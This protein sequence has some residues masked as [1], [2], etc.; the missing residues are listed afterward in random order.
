MSRLPRCRR[1]HRQTLGAARRARALLPAL[2]VLAATAPAGAQSYVNFEAGQVRPLALSP[3]GSRL[4]ATNTPDGQVEIF[5]VGAAGLTHQCSVPV[6]LEPVA[7][8]AASDTELWVVNHLSDSVSIVDVTSCAAARVRRT[9]LVGD[10]PRDIVFA[11]ADGQLAFITTA[12]R[13]QNHPLGSE[14]TTEGVGR[15]DVWVFDA[16]NLGASLEGD[17]ETIITLFGDTPRGLAV[18]RDGAR[19]YAAV[20]HSGNRTTTVNEGLVCDGGASAPACTI[21]GN[22]VPGGLP[23]P[24]V[25][26]NGV[27]GPETGLIVHW[28]P[29]TSHWEDPL[30]RNWNNAIR[31]SLPDLDVFEIDATANPPVERD[32]FAGVGTVLFNLAVNP[33]NDKVYVTNT[34]ANNAVR[35]EGPGTHSTTVRGNLHRARVTIIDPALGAVTPRPLNP[36][37]DYSVVP[38]PAGIAAKSLATPVGIVLSADGA[39]AWIAAFGSSKVGLFDTAELE[40]GTFTP[41]VANQVTVT[42]GGPSGLV[43]DEARDR[44]YVLTRFDNGIST[45][46]VGAMT[47]TAHT[48]L[49][50]PEPTAIVD[51]RPFLYDA[52]A[53][54]SNGE[55]SCSSCHVF[56]DLDSLAWDLGN[57]DDEVLT[58]ANP[59]EFGP[60]GS[61]DFHPLKGPM[62]TQSL[63]GMA[64]HGPMHW[65]GDRTGALEAASVQPDS[66]A[67]NEDAAFKKFNPAFV[68]LVGRDTTLTTA[69]MQKFTDFVLSVTYP[70]NPNRALNNAL[71]INA[72]SGEGLYFGPA[73]DGVRNCNGCHTLD[74]AQGFFGSD[75]E[76]TFENE[77]Q[78]FKVA[79]L[80]N[81]YQ[82][83]GMFGL[84]QVPFLGVADS[85]FIGDQIRGF[86]FLHDGSIPRLFDFFGATVFGL[87]DT[88]QRQMEAFSLEFPA[89]MAPV[90][91][92]QVTRSSTNGSV[93]NPRIN[94]LVA[95][96]A[97]GECDL[98]VKGTISGEPR[99]ALRLVS[100]AFATDRASEGTLTQAQLLALVTGTGSE[101]TWTCLPPGSGERAGI[102]RDEDG[103]RDRDELDQGTDPANAASY[104]G[105][106]TGILTSGFLLRD[107]N[108]PP[109]TA[110]KRTLTFKSAPYQGVSSGVTLP[111]A[112]SA[113]DP[114]LG[115]A[116]LAIYP[117][118]GDA[119]DVA[120]LDLPAAHWS[121]TGTGPTLAYRYTDPDHADG[122]VGLI[123]LSLGKLLI[124]GKGAELPTLSGAPLG[125]V[126]LRLTLG[127]GATLCA[128]APPREP[129]L[130][131]DNTARWQAVPNSAAPATCPAVP[132]AG[133][134]SRAFL[135]TTPGLVD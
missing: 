63:R 126:G 45:V 49:H 118:A 22:A 55:A 90:V 15:A 96:A 52:L 133:S 32:Q 62:T 33:V 51:G 34:E 70:P 93:T 42:G 37:I 2:L 121:A 30:G 5:A 119:G 105:A 112:G 129:A 39:S 132:G 81:M 101:Q 50:N 120:S 23:G 109:F 103:F 17:P 18:S 124:R 86:G 79:H 72:F 92:Q 97:A 9:L 69:D 127:S 83:V 100:G 77:T 98:V 125:E 128:S 67:F 108:L 73:S 66:G 85:G 94:L 53:T 114:T 56:G 40:A 115:G 27:A 54:S 11:G 38:S 3:D 41:A 29:L 20:F 135:S 80:R 106:P 6:G 68:G 84:P 102:D 10:E 12:H 35:F 14:S 43:L 95:R 48:L 122:P 113:N 104:P 107:D 21:N 130:N 76:S 59:F 25:D 4:F 123:K 116:T 13:G 117:L 87:S 19:V 31:F 44:L 61:P 64:G 110:T 46:D 57:P 36:H 71:S 26:A 28:N 134:A 88:Q 111:A 47:E 16:A 75:G 78:H 24:N 89:N 131:F 1:T 74:E 65:R 58:N 99:G 60:L 8:A 91:G 7:L 82:K